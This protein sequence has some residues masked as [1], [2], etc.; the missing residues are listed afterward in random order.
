MVKHGL[1]LAPVVVLVAGLVSG[2]DGAASAAIALAHR[3]RQLLAAAVDRAWAAK[4][5]PAAVGG[6]ALGGYICAS[7]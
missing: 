4:I 5:G 3:V 2:W 7:R 6:A 1:L